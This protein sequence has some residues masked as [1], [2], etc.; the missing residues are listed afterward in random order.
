MNS[1]TLRLQDATRIEEIPGVI[2]FVG[3]DASGSFGIQ[4][5]HDQLMTALVI[6]LA[7][8]RPADQD[9]QYLAMPGA[10]LRFADN[11]LTVNTLHY[12]RDHD[13]QRISAALQEQLLRE[14]EKVQGI[15]QSLHRIE[16]EVL[17]HLWQLGRG[18]V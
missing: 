18:E 13:Y 12:L 2:S 5:G 8:Y 4:A 15:K 14:E 10:L 3:E 9:W 1:F 6:G 16:Q 11:V 17:R 7:R